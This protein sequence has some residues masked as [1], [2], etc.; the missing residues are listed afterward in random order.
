MWRDYDGDGVQD[1]GEPGIAGARVRV[2]TI[3]DFVLRGQEMA[4][5][6]AI[7]ETVVTDTDGRY[8]VVA[9]VAG[10]YEVTLDLS[11]VTGTL[12]TPQQFEVPLD[13][14]EVYLDADFGLVLDDLPFTGFEVFRL[15]VIALSLVLLGAGVVISANYRRQQGSA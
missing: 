13:V 9:L 7:D 2:R 14:G 4:V 10:T 15:A 11:S 3:S 6:L 1:P 5:P 12:T 8:S